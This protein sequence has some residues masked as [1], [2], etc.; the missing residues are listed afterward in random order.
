MKIKALLAAL[1]VGALTTVNSHAAMPK[2]GEVAPA[3]EG[4]DQDGHTVK[5]ADFAGKKLV[6]L[7]FYP[8]DKIGRAHV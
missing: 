7:Y 5:L 4:L 6:L 1:L 3:F 2:A 8:K